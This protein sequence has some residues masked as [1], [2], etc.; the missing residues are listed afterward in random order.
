MVDGLPP[1][2]RR[3][4]QHAIAP[5][6]PLA[7][8]VELVQRGSM[9]P[10]PGGARVELSAHEV[11]TPERGFVWRA[12]LRMGPIPVRVVDHYLDGEGGVRVELFGGIP[13]QSESGADVARSSRGRTL[14]EALWVPSA[15][16]PGPNVAREAVDDDHAC[17][18]LTL[19]GEAVPLTLAVDADGH[20]RTLT[21]RRYGNV[22]VPDWQ[23][24]PYGFAIEREA[25]FGGY[26]IPSRLR[27][28]WWFG[29]D[30][31]DPAAASTFEILDA[32]YS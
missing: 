28:G 10:K 23:P 4:L 12:R 17:V 13:L 3:Y 11:L 1:P 15:L 25:T 20:L 29:T 5:G 32:H 2:A 8:T 26:T 22:G 7:R 6:T 30:R 31:Y 21:M 24:L 16:L 9:L 18:T 27:G 19:D 14:G